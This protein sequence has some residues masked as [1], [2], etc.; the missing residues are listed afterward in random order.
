M[1]IF[2]PHAIQFLSFLAMLI[3]TIV[4]GLGFMLVMHEE[5]D[6]ALKLA[7]TTDS[8]T[9]LANRRRFNE[10]LSIEFGRL[11]RSGAPLSLI[12][13]DVDHFK[14]F[15]DRYGHVQGDECLRRISQAIK[16]V[17]CRASDLAARY[18]GE[19]FVVVAPETD[20]KGVMT[21]AENIRRAVEEL[22]IPHKDNTA[23]SHVTVSLGVV[24]RAGT[25]L[26]R[27]ESFVDL[28]DQALYEA[29]QTGRNRTKVM[30]TQKAKAGTGPG[31]VRLVWNGMAESGNAKLDEQ[32][33]AL[34]DHANQ[35][36]SAVLKGRP[37][38]ECKSLLDQTLEAII[39][40][41][42]DEEA[43][44]MGTSFPDTEHHIQCHRA[45]L[46]KAHE[47]SERFDQNELS[48]GELFSFL[49]HEVVAQHILI[50]D[51]KFF[52]YLE[53]GDQGRTGSLSEFLGHRTP[54]LIGN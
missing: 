51:M 43:V 14:R 8:L 31:L 2:T 52:P 15:N 7:A 54:A 50:E 39:V 44:L 27:P 1:T 34:F 29:K 10:V 28:A 23:A 4:S 19:E 16:T 47:M 20:A 6:K 11:K 5:S 32:H 38:Q 53:Q 35:L 41:F 49:A 40:H 46:T 45:L 21:L 26:E 42:K 30:L 24:T 17:V 9:T 37:K 48:I 33:K 18:G 22:V 13:L 3:A 12:M 36:L 25:E